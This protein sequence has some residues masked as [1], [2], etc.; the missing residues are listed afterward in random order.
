MSKG[1]VLGVWGRYLPM[2]V[3]IYMNSGQVLG[4]CGHYL[5][6]NVAIYMNRGRSIYEQ[7]AQ[8]I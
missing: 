2:N 3:A 8:Y 6:I 1:K 7:G 5:Q 4:V